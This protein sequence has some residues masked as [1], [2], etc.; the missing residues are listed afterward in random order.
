MLRMGK[1]TLV[2]SVGQAAW[3]T[4][5]QWR[6]LPAERRDRL[7]S[8]VR[9][10]AGGPS[11]LSAAERRD[12]E[13]SSANCALAKCCVTARCVPHAVDLAAGTEPTASTIITSGSGRRA[14]AVQRNS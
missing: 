2:A 13:L 12:S 10:S 3:S 5:R 11:N 7:Q 4:R 1:M 6:A 14:R 9:Q 8:L